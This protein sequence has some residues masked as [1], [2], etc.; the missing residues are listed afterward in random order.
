VSVV[1]YCNCNTLRCDID[2]LPVW[3]AAGIHLCACYCNCNAV[4]CDI[5]F[6]PVWTAAGIG[7]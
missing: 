1:C 2:L 3:T 6:L 5:E 7:L 4:C